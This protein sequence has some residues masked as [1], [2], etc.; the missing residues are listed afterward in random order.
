MCTALDGKRTLR[1]GIP[2]ARIPAAEPMRTPSIAYK[3]QVPCLK[4][5][6]H[7]EDVLDFPRAMDGR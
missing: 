7:A 5:P 2:G 1:Q 3:L 4:R 6:A